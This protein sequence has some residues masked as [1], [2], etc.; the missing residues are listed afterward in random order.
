M[1]AGQQAD[2]GGAIIYRR[3][4]TKRQEDEGT[5][6]DSQEAAC[7]NHAQ[8]LGFT[9]W[10]V[11]REVYSGAALYDRPLLSRDRADLK[12]GQFKALIAYST[13]RLSR[14]PFTWR[15]SPKTVSATG[16]PSCLSQS[17]L[18]RRPKGS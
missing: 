4:S 1:D 12:S 3:V 18:I 16:Y 13:D 17:H 15:Y 10:R 9:S 6:L 14:D 11:T 8:A 5:S 2:Q 7:V